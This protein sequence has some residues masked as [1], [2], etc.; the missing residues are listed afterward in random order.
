MLKKEIDENNNAGPQKQPLQ[1]LPYLNAVVKETMR[2]SKG[3]PAHLS[4]VVPRG[5][6]TFQGVHFPRNTIVGCSIYT[7]S[8]SPEIFPEPEAFRPERWLEEKD[9]AEM[10]KNFFVFGAGTRGCIARN[11]LEGAKAC[12]DKIEIWEWFNSR[13]KEDRG[14][15]LVWEKQ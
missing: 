2:T 5:G 15:E 10:S 8:L 7:L 9:T 4:R 11:V 6:W 12:Q 3:T 1:N 14:I 13:V